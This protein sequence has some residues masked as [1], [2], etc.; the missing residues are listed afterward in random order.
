MSSYNTVTVTTAA[1]LILDANANR[2]SLI[3]MNVSSGTVFI[4]QDTSLT[5]ANG[6][7]LA[8]NA[9]FTEWIDETKVYTGPYY[10]RVASGTSDMRYWERT[11]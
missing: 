10:G 9:P 1:T 6:I 4:A 7:A 8:Q 2:L 5:T 3:L 11:T